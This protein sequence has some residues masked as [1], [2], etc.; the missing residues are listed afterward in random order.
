[1]S[2]REGYRYKRG[3]NHPRAKHS[4]DD[5]RLMRELKDEGLGYGT[6]AKKFETSKGT[7]R[8]VCTYRTR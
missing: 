7:V 1:M 6:I 8:N 2:R 3:E 5:V 4:D